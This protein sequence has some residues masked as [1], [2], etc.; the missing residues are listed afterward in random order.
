MGGRQSE[1]AKR[2]R[3]SNLARGRQQYREDLRGQVLD[4]AAAIIE[5]EGAEAL[6]M[7]KLGL[8]LGWAP[9]SLYSYFGDKHELLLALAHRSF[10]ALALRLAGSDDPPLDALRR[11]FLA[12]A[13]FGL[14]RPHHYRT[15]FM[16]VETQPPRE[17][18]A[19]EQISAENP[20][21]A[22]ALQ[23]AQACVA[24]GLLAGDPHAIATLL[25]TTVHG[26]VAAMLTFPAFPFGNPTAYAARAFDLTIAAMREKATDPLD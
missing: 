6:S 12:Y 16:A 10:D 15:M 24:A 11:L 3:P 1:K 14:E 20:A 19:P 4:A 7:R 5:T 18:K 17:R 21:F 2:S 8:V 25:W 23:R 22:I 26:A 9:M 13:R